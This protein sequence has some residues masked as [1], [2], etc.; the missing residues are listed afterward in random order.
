LLAPGV[1]TNRN[2]SHY[3]TLHIPERIVRTGQ[4]RRNPPPEMKSHSQLR[5][6]AM[7]PEFRVKPAPDRVSLQINRDKLLELLRE[8]HLCATDF[9]CLDSESSKCV[10]R[11]LLAACE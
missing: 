1:F 5:R 8:R 6:D 2:H 4:G 10:W 7:P 9:T 11:L 3:S